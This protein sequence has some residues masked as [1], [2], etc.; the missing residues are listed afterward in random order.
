MGSLAGK[1]VWVWNWPRCDGGDP[2]L[3]AERLK[4]AGCVGAIVKAW[5]GTRWFGQG[6]PWREIGRA[7][8]A[9]GLAAGAWGYCYGQDPRGEAVRA[10]ETAGYGEAGLLVLDVEG[11]LKGRPEAAQELC[12]RLRDG[13][14]PDYPLYF[15][16]YAVARYHRSFPFD[17]FSAYCTGA[18]PQ[19]YWNAFGWPVA[20]ALA[21]TYE[22]YASLGIP[23]GRVFPAGG[24][25]NEGAVAYPRPED[26]RW[27]T[28][29]AAAKG[30]AGVSFWS[31]EHMSEAMWQ[32]VRGAAGRREEGGM[33]SQEFDQVMREVNGLSWRV[34]QLE[35]RV[36]ELAAPLAGAPLPRTYTVQPGDTLSGIAAK[37]GLPDWR[38]LYE[39]NAG[40]IGPDP[41]LIHPGQVLAVP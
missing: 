12:L 15:S 40:V 18:V 33:S 17:V 5:D 9:R 24:V 27:F 16:S 37:L 13:L 14:G 35:A 23:P 6:I 2:D 19:V 3:V 29:Q 28:A 21:M 8:K 41:D 32:A 30:S 34:G 1:W 38:Q 31:Y 11:E 25:Y 22:D 7:L 39:A 4:A 36:A 26:V 20:E 10:I